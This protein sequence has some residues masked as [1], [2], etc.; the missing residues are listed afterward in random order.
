MYNYHP[1]KLE[2]IQAVQRLE[3]ACILKNIRLDTA[4]LAFSLLNPQIDVTVI[5]ASS[6]QRLRQALDVCSSPLTK[7]DFDE[8]LLAVGGEFPLTSPYD[9]NPWND[10]R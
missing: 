7:A 5:G 1:A 3:A 8:L 6:I 9:S 4:A 2:V 10:D